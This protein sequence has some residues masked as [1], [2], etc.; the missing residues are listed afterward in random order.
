M[1]WIRLAGIILAL[2]LNAESVHCAISLDTSTKT[3][4]KI[5]KYKNK[6]ISL[7]EKEREI[8]SSIYKMT[9][10]QRKLAAQKAEYLEQRETLEA[11][12]ADLQK[13]IESVG[14][15]IKKMRRKIATRTRNLYKI[16]TPTIFQSIFGSQHLSEMD[17]NARILYKLSKTEMVQLRDYR[18]LKHLLDQKQQELETKLVKLESTQKDLELKEKDIKSNYYAQMG[19][20]QKLEA[21]DKVI[22]DKLKK[23]KKESTNSKNSFSI[24]APAFANGLYEKKGQLDLPVSGIVTQKFGLLSLMQEKI[25]VYHKGWFISCVPG[26]DVLAVHDGTVAFVGTIPERQNVII[27]DHGDHFYSVYANLENVFVREG[28]TITAME[29]LGGA[30]TSRL[31]GHGLYFEIRHFSQSEDPVEWFDQNRLHISSLKESAL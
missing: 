25:K 17:R 8:L 5:D 20:L 30:G 13:N 28:D 3:N 7:Q 27:I 6:S 24:Y 22:V 19:L 11:D 18:G 16:N 14:E 21:E 4:E 15:Q 29:A 12:V 26:K 31:F 2:F 10:R 1:G 23:M 9:R